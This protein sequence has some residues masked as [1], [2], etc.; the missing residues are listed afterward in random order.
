MFYVD[1]CTFTSF[2]TKACSFFNGEGAVQVKTLLESASFQERSV[3][4]P[5]EGTPQEQ[6]DISSFFMNDLS[7]F[8]ACAAYVFLIH[9]VYCRFH[10]SSILVYSLQLAASWILLFPYSFHCF[11]FHCSNQSRF[12]PNHSISLTPALSNHPLLPAASPL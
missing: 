2:K 12:S 7:Q 10:P 9:T 4:T 11:K 6:V 8:S 3:T 5:K 1:L